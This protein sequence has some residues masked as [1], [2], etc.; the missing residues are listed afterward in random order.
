MTAAE[1]LCSAIRDT[2]I[3][4]FGY[5]DAQD[6]R[7]EPYVVWED[8]QDNWQLGGWSLGYSETQSDPPWRTY[9][10]SDIR[11]VV[12]ITTETFTGLRDGYDRNADRY[13]EACCKV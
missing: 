6:H 5:N 2:R 3:V 1:K 8:G 9:T 7:V 12:T 11:G 13:A 4:E 10:I